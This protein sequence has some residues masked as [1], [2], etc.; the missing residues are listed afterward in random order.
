MAW[1]GGG[2]R[3]GSISHVLSAQSKRSR[4]PGACTGGW[5]E[6]AGPEPCRGASGEAP[7]DTDL[8]CLQPRP[9][10]TLWV[11]STQWRPMNAHNGARHA[12][13][14]TALPNLASSVPRGSTVT[15]CFH[16]TAR[17]I[18]DSHPFARVALC[19]SGTHLARPSGKSLQ[20]LHASVTGVLTQETTPRS[21]RRP[22][23]NIC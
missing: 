18:C 10:H 6:G 4:S 12:V 23:R 14:L 3:S 20:T 17:G 8:T 22:G 1:G 21:P 7:G 19:S 9:Q 16:V 15:G 11:P 13:V 2:G 5:E